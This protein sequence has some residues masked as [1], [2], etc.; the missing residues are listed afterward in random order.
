M[1][2]CGI[3]QAYRTDV[4]YYAKQGVTKR[5][6]SDIISTKKGSDIYDRP[7]Q[8]IEKILF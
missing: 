4:L 3:I 5:K 8:Q 1:E 2:F 6:L 7:K